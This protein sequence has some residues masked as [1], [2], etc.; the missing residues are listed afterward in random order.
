MLGAMIISLS[1]ALLVTLITIIAIY[2][3]CILIFENANGNLKKSLS[4]KKMV[5]NKREKEFSVL[6]RKIQKPR[7]TVLVKNKE[8]F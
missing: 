3:I 7:K 5:N 6:N 1:L 2:A 8:F 4:A